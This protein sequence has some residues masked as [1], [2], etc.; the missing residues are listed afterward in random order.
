MS[1]FCSSTDNSAA[2]TATS[3]GASQETRQAAKEEVKAWE[4]ELGMGVLQLSEM[5]SERSHC[6]L[7]FMQVNGEKKQQNTTNKSTAIKSQDS[8]ERRYMPPFVLSQHC[9]SKTLCQMAGVLHAQ[10]YNSVVVQTARSPNRWLPPKK[11]YQ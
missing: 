8:A 1:Q 5:L 4:P 11:K 10:K 9:D 6:S 2:A 7:H 3:R